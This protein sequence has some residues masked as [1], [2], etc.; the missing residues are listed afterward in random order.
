MQARSDAANVGALRLKVTLAI[1]AAGWVAFVAHKAETFTDATC[2]MLILAVGIIPVVIWVLQWRDT[3]PVMPMVGLVYILHFS[4]PFTSQTSDVLNYSEAEKLAGALTVCGFLAAATAT[5][6]AVMGFVRIPRQSSFSLNAARIEGLL[7]YGFAVAALFNWM[8]LT[9]DAYQ[10]GSFHPVVRAVCG[11]IFFV[12]AYLFG[13]LWADRELNARTKALCIALFSFAAVITW[14]STYLYPSMFVIAMFF[15][16]YMIS[17]R[18]VPIALVAVVLAVFVVLQAGKSSMRDRYQG[19]RV[20]F[21]TQEVPGF[22][23]E[24]IGEGLIGLTTAGEQ[25][26]VQLSDRIGLM[27]M[28]LRAQQM[29]PSQVDFLNGETYAL[30][31]SLMVPRFIDPDKPQAHAGLTLLNIRYGILLPEEAERTSVGWGMLSE[32]YANYG[33]AGVIGLGLLLGALY[34]VATIWSSGAPALSG[35]AMFGVVLLIMTFNLEANM[36]IYLTTLFQGAVAIIALVL[37]F[38]VFGQDPRRS[39]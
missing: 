16:G 33:N 3:L 9:G 39:A 17:A 28:L 23:A 38:R 14:S 15:I 6:A 25:Q 18:R 8:E 19:E 37:F 21:S 29:T 11:S 24:W 31:P 34:A 10:F 7:P 4:L 27:H 30:I 26:S 13:V 32:A 5:W 1:I 36:A 2:P 35:R 22:V 12:S 20:V